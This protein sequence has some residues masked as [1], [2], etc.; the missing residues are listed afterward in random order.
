[1]RSEINHSA[2]IQ[3]NMYG[4]TSQKDDIKRYCKIKIKNSHIIKVKH[5]IVLLRS[6]YKK[7]LNDLY[8]LQRDLL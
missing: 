3:K 6:L 1:M 7:D 2:Q 5:Y 4:T 8:K